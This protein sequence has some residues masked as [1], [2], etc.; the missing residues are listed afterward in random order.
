MLLGLCPCLGWA[1][2]NAPAH[3][4]VEST[5][6]GAGPRKVSLPSFQMGGNHGVNTH[7][8]GG[9]DSY[10][11]Q[12][13]AIGLEALIGA[14]PQIPQSLI[15]SP[16][17]GAAQAATGITSQLAPGAA[18]LSP[19]GPES[20][21]NSGAESA[22]SP[23]G[24]GSGRISQR[25]LSLAR[26]LRKP[27]ADVANLALRGESEAGAASAGRD[28]QNILESQIGPGQTQGLEAEIERAFGGLSP[29]ENYARLA[30]D[31]QPIDFSRESAS[32]V[33]LSQNL[34]SKLVPGWPDSRGLAEKGSYQSPWRAAGEESNPRRHEVSHV[35]SL[36]AMDVVDKS[37]GLILFP[38]NTLYIPV[39]RMVLPRTDIA[40]P[41]YHLALTEP[42]R[43]AAPRPAPAASPLSFGAQNE[44]HSF[45]EF[46]SQEPQPPSFSSR[47]MDSQLIPGSEPLSAGVSASAGAWAGLSL[48][49][50]LLAALAARKQAE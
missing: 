5:H 27:L 49:S 9:A 11:Y 44:F 10:G 28:I 3:L 23:A 34:P 42:R 16:A 6:Q 13:A 29:R 33:L 21:L 12:P 41:V 47:K 24:P 14:L 32:R 31:A 8:M 22:F 39:A 25:V 4:Q 48:L 40:L 50:F 19:A 18:F 30:L 38:A 17:P 20:V 36:I 35:V 26:A 37:L 45:S 15:Y 46:L 7:G 1:A 43:V 2:N